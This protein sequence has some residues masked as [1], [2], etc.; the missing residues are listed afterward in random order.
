M[1]SGT[2][3]A[4][5]ELRA[6]QQAEQPVA[7]ELAQIYEHV[8]DVDLLV[9]CLAE[10][11]PNGFGFSD[12]AFRIFIVMATRRIK[13]DRFYTDDYHAGVYTQLG[14][15]WVRDNGFHTVVS[16]HFPSL[17]NKVGRVRNGFFPWPID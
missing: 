4:C 7:A 15:D 8:D 5:A 2:R 6:P 12:T 3:I 17:A 14:M 16:R 13:S 10:K 1:Q 11:P 9:G